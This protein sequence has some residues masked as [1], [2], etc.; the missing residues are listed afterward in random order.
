MRFS[1]V[2]LDMEGK[3]PGRIFVLFASCLPLTLGSALAQSEQ[4]EP[5]TEQSLLYIP[6][7]P[8]PGGWPSVDAWLP[9]VPQDV[10]SEIPPTPGGWPPALYMSGG[11]V[12]GGWPP[13]P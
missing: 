4:V 9:F 6:E 12:E 2:H 7:E 3:M 8:T 13:D 11:E 5:G 1:V 10:T